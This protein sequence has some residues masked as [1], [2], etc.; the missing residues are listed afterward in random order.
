MN[1]SKHYLIH[2]YKDKDLKCFI[3]NVPCGCN[4][5]KT[6]IKIMKEAAHSDIVQGLYYFYHVVEQTMKTIDIYPSTEQTED[7]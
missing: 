3:K 7:I 1:D 6:A 5:R 2:A 4:H